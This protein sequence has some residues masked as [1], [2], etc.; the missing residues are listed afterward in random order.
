MLNSNRL[1]HPHQK[2]KP[3]QPAKPTHRE[4]HSANLRRF[5][6]IS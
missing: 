2:S 4:R 5:R 6:I 3:P 1:L